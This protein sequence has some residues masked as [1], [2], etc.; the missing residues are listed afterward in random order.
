[1]NTLMAVGLFYV[2]ALPAD[3]SV[4]NRRP[5]ETSGLAV[6]HIEACTIPMK[7]LA[8]SADFVGR[9]TYK[10]TVKADGMVDNVTRLDD[11]VTAAQFVDL[12]AFDA[13]LRRWRFE[14]SGSY[15]VY[16]HGGTMSPRWTIT[17]WI[18]NEAMRLIVPRF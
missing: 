15:N 2:L 13:C 1:M 3:Q 17:V 18:G 12:A 14:K 4:G 6:R 16:L 9:W 8:G 11:P 7:H 5:R 10:V